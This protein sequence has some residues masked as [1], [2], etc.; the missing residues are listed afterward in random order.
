MSKEIKLTRE[1]LY[2]KI[3]RTPTTK[4][5]KD[6][7]ISDVALTKICRKMDVPKPPPGYWRR[8]ETGATPKTVPLP[9]STKETREFIYITIPTVRPVGADI[10]A[11]IDREDLPENQ[12][13]VAADL[14]EAHLL[15]ERTKE[16]FDKN[17]PGPDE[18]ITAPR[19]KGYLDMSVSPAQANRAF[20]IMDALIKALEDRGYDIAVSAD[21]WGEE[22]RITKD[23]E[24]VR[25]SLYERTRA[26]QRDLKPEEKKKPPYLLDIPT[27]YKANGTL[28]LTINTRW[29]AYQ[30]WSDRKTLLLEERLNDVMAGIISLLESLVVEKRR[31]DEAGRRRLEEIRQREEE[32]RLREQ[33]ESDTSQWHK[34]RSITEYLDAY[35]AKLLEHDKAIVPGTR[36]AE[37]LTWARQYADSLDP[38]NKIFSTKESDQR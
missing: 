36:E 11:M 32:K 24:E 4:L 20:L 37:W 2:E 10:Q 5:A 1:E 21:H 34:S 35:E 33:L 28:N 9:R 30:K 15:V 22:T 6:F 29:S 19:G 26:I 31:K 7:G 38:L 12:I 23:G 14:T 17:D 3:W 25:I 18:L 27:E 16:F 13:T 8:I